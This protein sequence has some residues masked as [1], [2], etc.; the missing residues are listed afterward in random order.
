M[1]QEIKTITLPLPFKM[2][3]VNCYLVKTDGGYILIDTGGSNARSELE[4]AL[5]SA[6]CKPGNLELIVLTHGD[7]DHIG[8]A[9]YLRGKFGAKVAM[10]R[11]DCGMAERGDMF[12]N[13]KSGNAL[14]RIL[15]PVLFRFGQANRFQPDV[16][17]A[18]GDRLSEYGFDATVLEIP[19]H[20]KGSIGILTAEGDLFC[21]DLFENTKEPALNAIMDDI[22]TAQVSVE[23]LKGL[24]INT[25]Y[26]GHGKSF[27]L[28]QLAMK[29]G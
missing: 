28:D 24:G 3:S 16:C 1:Q 21:G 5:Q 20:S 29:G 15:A 22:A 10:H 14:I 27:L 2:G 4:S 18:D 9:A 17:F 12:W 7:F 23:K 8:N 19:G 6:G 13:R 25:V 11:D 26:P